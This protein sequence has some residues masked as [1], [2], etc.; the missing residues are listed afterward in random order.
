[1]PRKLT[2]H[3]TK[4]N[5][6]EQPYCS[7]TAWAECYFWSAKDERLPELA[8]ADKLKGDISNVKENRRLLADKQFTTVHQD[9]CVSQVGPSETD[10]AHR[11]LLQDS[12]SRHCLRRQATP[13]HSPPWTALHDAAFGDECAGGHSGAVGPPF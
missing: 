4:P 5:T 11:G 8:A 6:S 1:M 7:H 13:L 2:K 3:T 10:D 9:V 12:C